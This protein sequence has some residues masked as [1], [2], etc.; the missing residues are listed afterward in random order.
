MQSARLVVRRFLDKAVRLALVGSLAAVPVAGF[1]TLEE[2]TPEARLVPLGLPGENEPVAYDPAE[3][4]LGRRLFFETALSRERTIS[5]SSC[6]RPEHGFADPRRRSIGDRGEKTL[7]HAPTLLNRAF[8]EAFFWDG[9]AG[10]IEEQVLQPIANEREMDLPLE[11]ALERLNQDES[12]RSAFEAVYQ[13]PAEAESLASALAAFVRTLLSGDSPVD[14]FRAGER[15]ALSKAARSGMWLF[16]SRGRCWR[17]HAGA[18]FSDEEFHNTGVAARSGDRDAGR[19]EVT[20]D[21]ADRGR[22]KTPT[23]RGLVHTA[24]YM[25]DGSLATLEEVVELY[26]DGGHANANLDPLIEPIEMSDEDVQNLAAFLRALSTE[27]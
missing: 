23:L 20:G 12:Y 4:E 22:F 13:A 15:S 26:R 7:R 27:R 9:R 14:R 6:H 5:C 11:A 19:F 1:A 17:C 10:T 21:E 18:N 2:A 25:H 8:G 16:E 24:P 3:V